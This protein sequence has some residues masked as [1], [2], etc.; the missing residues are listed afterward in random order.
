MA[1]LSLIHCA[2]F[3][4]IL[5]CSIEFSFNLHTEKHADLRHSAQCTF[6]YAQTPVTT[7][8]VTP[9]SSLV[10]LPSPHPPPPREVAISL[11]SIT[12]DYFGP[13]LELH[14][15][16]TIRYVLSGVWLLSLNITSIKTLF[17]DQKHNTCSLQKIANNVQEGKKST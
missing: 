5:F 11:T 3:C 17:Y 9:E 13:V 15:N 16:G 6:T 7:N 2:T 14:I 8:H 4:L 12:I 10:P 1:V